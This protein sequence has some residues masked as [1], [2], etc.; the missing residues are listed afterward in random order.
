MEY[1]CTDCKDPFDKT[2]KKNKS[3]K[4]PKCYNAAQRNR[5]RILREKAAAALASVGRKLITKH[6]VAHECCHCG[7]RLDPTTEREHSG[8][9]G[10]QCGR[11][12]DV[13]VTALPPKL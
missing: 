1:Y 10:I 9:T 7:G 6:W 3:G 2:Q 13:L 12:G 5:G 4:C 8:M 11:C